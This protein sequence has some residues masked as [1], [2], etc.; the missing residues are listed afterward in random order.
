MICWLSAHQ[1]IYTEHKKSNTK[2]KHTS[3]REWNK[4]ME[5]PV[6]HVV[7]QHRKA[8]EQAE[9]DNSYNKS[10]K[11]TWPT[12]KQ[13]LK[14]D[15][16]RINSAVT[17]TFCGNNVSALLHATPQHTAA[18]SFGRKS[19]NRARKPTSLSLHAAVK[20]FV[21]QVGIKHKNTTSEYVMF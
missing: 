18:N 6:H 14:R 10:G 7:K 8:P 11:W 5:W 3:R 9:A 4:G 16:L 1:G 13:R 15:I 20:N 2:L 21:S 19:G 17:E 12:N